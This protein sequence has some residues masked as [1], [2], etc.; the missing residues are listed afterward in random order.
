MIFFEKKHNYFP[1]QVIYSVI[2]LLCTHDILQKRTSHSLV[3]MV[4]PLLAWVATEFFT[5]AP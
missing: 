1:F 2:Q 5:V 3:A 4:S